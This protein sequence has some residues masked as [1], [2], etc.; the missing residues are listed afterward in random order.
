MKISFADAQCIVDEV[1]GELECLVVDSD[2]RIR[3]GDLFFERLHHWSGA[4]HVDG[5]IRIEGK[6]G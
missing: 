1:A 4:A 5:G 3:F 6:V 2:A